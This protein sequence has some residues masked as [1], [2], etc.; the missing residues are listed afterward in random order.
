VFEFGSFP[1]LGPVLFTNFIIYFHDEGT[2]PIE[3][4]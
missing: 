4:V 3:A 2:L 1:N